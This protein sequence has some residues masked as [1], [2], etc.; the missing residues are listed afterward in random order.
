MDFASK[1][2]GGLAGRR[3]VTGQ[4]DLFLPGIH[5]CTGCLSPRAGR[6]GFGHQLPVTDTRVCVLHPLGGAQV[7]LDT[8]AG[9][10]ETAGTPLTQSRGQEPQESCPCPT[11]NSRGRIGCP[12]PT[13]HILRATPRS[14]Q[15]SPEAPFRGYGRS[16][17]YY[18]GV[19][20]PAPPRLPAI[21][22]H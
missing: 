17:H 18:L 9:A 5:P 10:E 4:T 13:A 15:P 21:R 1:P 19:L 16:P 20:L 8:K 12:R 2:T 22:P 7:G 6:G 11:P 3:G 14:C